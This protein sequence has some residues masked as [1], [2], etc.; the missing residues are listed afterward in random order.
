M[1]SGALSR[2]ILALLSDVILAWKTLPV[3]SIR[4]EFAL[5]TGTWFIDIKKRPIGTN[6]WNQEWATLDFW[7]PEV[8]FAEMEWTFL[9]LLF[10][11]I[12]FRP[13]LYHSSKKLPRLAKQ[14]SCEWCLTIY[15]HSFLII[16]LNLFYTEKIL[17]NTVYLT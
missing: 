5:P 3:L 1:Q 12:P 4:A 17:F 2:Q 14:S 10:N 7:P 16:S 15:S 6:K 13:K 11:I 9:K 8:L